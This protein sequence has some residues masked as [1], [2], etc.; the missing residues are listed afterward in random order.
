VKKTT[1]KL[2]VRYTRDQIP[3]VISD[4]YKDPANAFIITLDMFFLARDKIEGKD[5][6]KGLMEARKKAIDTHQLNENMRGR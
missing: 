2:F 3:D 1:D 6:E 5:V 4:L